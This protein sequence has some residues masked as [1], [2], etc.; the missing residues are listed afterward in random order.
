MEEMQSELAEIKEAMAEALTTGAS[1]W[2]LK[3]GVSR[4]IRT[5]PTFPLVG[6]VNSKNQDPAAGDY[7]IIDQNFIAGRGQN[8]A[9]GLGNGSRLKRSCMPSPPKRSEIGTNV[10]KMPCSKVFFARE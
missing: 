5:A 9:C 6:G 1:P 8:Q 4:C 2:C 7:F 10:S 3:S